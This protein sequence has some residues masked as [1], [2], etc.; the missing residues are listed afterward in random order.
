M[1]FQS[2]K[3]SVIII[4]YNQ[5]K[6]ISECLESVFNQSVL[7][8]EVI[9]ADDCSNDNT[10]QIIQEYYYKYPNI[11]KPVTNKINIGIYNNLNNALKLTTGNVLSGMGGDDF[12]E[13]DLFENL[14]KSII[15]NNIDVNNEKFIVVTNTAHYYPN[16][17]ITIFNNNNLRSKNIFKEQLRNGVSLRWIGYSLNLKEYMF[18]SDEIGYG[19][20][21]VRNA[22]IILNCHKFIFGNFISTYY[23]VGVGVTS[24]L[25]LR[26]HANYNLKGLPFF[27]SAFETSIDKSDKKYLTFYKS[28]NEYHKDPGFFK[29][30]KMLYW[31][32]LNLGNF[33]VNNSFAKNSKIVFPFTSVL[34]YIRKIIFRY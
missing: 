18:S 2:I 25:K 29:Y 27:I 6:Y 5:E 33:S 11:L 4:S 14:N 8:Y 31:Y 32:I 19:A 13:K 1:K 9:V 26:E 3:H 20:D 10:W 28:L 22:N 34:Y 7:P 24:K 12:F 21:W 16:K 15:E 30:F 17:K 23:R